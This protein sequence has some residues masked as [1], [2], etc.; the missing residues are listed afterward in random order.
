MKSFMYHYI[1]EGDEAYP[2]FRYLHIEDFKKQVSYFK[3]HYN[4]IS[5]SEFFNSIE[6]KEPVE[7]AAI[8]TFDDG[9]IDHFEAAEYLAAEGLWG[10]FYIP[11]GPYQTQKL[12]DVHRIHVLIGK[13]GGQE[14]LLTLEKTLR[15]SYIQNEYV[16]KFEKV[17]YAR[18]DN[19]A[20]TKQVKQILNYFLDY[21]QKDDVLD[22]L[23]Q[24]Y[25][26]DEALLCKDFYLS[27]TQI[28]SMNNMGMV[29]G[30]HSVTHPVFS[31]LD[32]ATQNNEIM[33]CFK[34]LDDFVPSNSIKTFCYPYGGDHSF[35]ED[36]LMILEK[37]NVD[38]SFSVEQRDIN[39]HD[40]IH[41]KQA[42][43]RYDCNQFPF[44]QASM[45]LKRA[46]MMAN[47]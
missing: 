17:T 33:N 3:H 8:L 18:Q 25:F 14:I 44:G 9:L 38:F 2:W 29:I 39:A 26:P 11:T 43:P 45:G 34:L 40:L 47:S 5:K 16:D 46:E 32:Y 30:A 22:V 23:M 19:D 15:E 20:A 36:T 42:L 21:Q 1:R 31:R 4:F 10:I 6:Q 41:K 28:K 13:Y 37:E 27:P 35:N 12:L 24:K 7:N